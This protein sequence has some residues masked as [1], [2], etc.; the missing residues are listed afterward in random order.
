[1]RDTR[2][3]G[4]EWPLCGFAEEGQGRSVTAT[5]RRRFTGYAALDRRGNLLWGT[6]ATK[7]EA[8][9]AAHDRYNPDPTGEGMGER[10]VPVKIILEVE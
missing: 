4:R 6:L 1:M 10:I 2:R 8:A 7:A 3:A 5:R 9:Q